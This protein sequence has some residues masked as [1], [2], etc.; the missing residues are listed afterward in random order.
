M[1]HIYSIKC[2]ATNTQMTRALLETVINY[3]SPMFPL[4]KHI[5]LIQINISNKVFTILI[6]RLS[7]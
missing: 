5:N 2:T 4:N 3:S 1:T 7:N 6:N